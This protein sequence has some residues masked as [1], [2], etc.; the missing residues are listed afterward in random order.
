MRNRQEAAVESPAIYPITDLRQDA[1]R[2]VGKVCESG[3]PAFI[4]QRGR[5]AAVLM[6]LDAYE[7]TQRELAI[8]RIL[9]TGEAE[10]ARGE[11]VELDDVLAE[12]R[13][14][15]AGRQG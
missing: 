9:A 7:K 14:K 15:L 11:G 6:S 8:L 2:L 10:S 12:A 13:A 4:T 5:A 3:R 1:T